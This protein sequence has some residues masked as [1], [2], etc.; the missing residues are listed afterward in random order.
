MLVIFLIIVE[1]C[2]YPG[3]LA[4][5][6]DAKLPDTSPVTEPGFIVFL[7]R[8]VALVC[9]WAGAAFLLGLA[10]NRLWRRVRQRAG[11]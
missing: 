8:N 3:M 6:A 11:I 5:A 9:M 4:E 1:A 2:L 7:F 10:T